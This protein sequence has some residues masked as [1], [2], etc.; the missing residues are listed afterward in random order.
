MCGTCRKVPVAMA[1]VEF[2]F[3]CWPGGPVIPPPCRRCGSRHGYYAGGLCS[4]CH[5]MAI[6]PVDSCR[7]CHAWGVTRH[8][9]WLCRG[10]LSWR[11]NHSTIGEC[12]TCHTTI[13]LGTEGVCRLCR[14]QATLVRDRRGQLDVIAAN[15]Q[16]QQLFL[17]D[18]FSDHSPA[19]RR[20][21]DWPAVEAIRPA[22]H[23]QMLLFTMPRNLA[24]HGRANMPAPADPHLATQLDER[25]CAQATA[26]AWGLKL[27]ANSR[28]GIRIL[29]GLQDT[30][31]AAVNAS[32]VAQ[33]RTIGLPVWTVMEILAAAGMLIEDRAPALDQWFNAQIDGLPQ[34]M[35]T[36]VS[37]WYQI[38]RN[39]RPTTPRRRPR[40]ETTVR[41]HTTWA[42]PILRAW[43]TSG[44]TSLREITKH[45]ILDAL[46]ASGNPRST[47]GQGLKS[48]FKVLREHKILFTN[49]TS[50]V[51]TGEHATRQ[52]V[53]A[54]LDKIREAL[55]SRN[56]AQAT[57]VALIAFHGLRTGHI[58]RL[59]LTDLHDARLHIDGRIIVL[60][61]PVTATLRRWLDY[62][63]T[64]FPNTVN[65]HLFIH[66][67]SAC[68]PD[69]PVGHRW[70]RLTI[71]EGLTGTLIR[72]DRILNEVHATDGDTRRLVDLFGL[73]VQAS[74]RYTATLDHPSLIGEATT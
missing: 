12:L 23:E 73:S 19:Q 60:A 8:T 58:Q 44:R 71:G 72:E 20:P 32:E 51:K 26:H 22:R 13:T 28:I 74:S 31:G 53:P 61:K 21:D 15:T 36:E 40:C 9:A 34:P 63:Q 56:V 37:T 66:Y 43:A 62:R 33:L 35:H 65:D 49:P 30:P 10:C 14:K 54:N 50:R 48:I 1:Q 3:T 6:P 5:P 45:D 16:G 52:P 7:D 47:A 69:T 70:V 46:P 64:R 24:A 17:A 38:M 2:C 29:L 57:V 11:R 55:H 27:T 41:L 67:R 25:A 68:H 39:G 59:K 18:M 4:R 42:L